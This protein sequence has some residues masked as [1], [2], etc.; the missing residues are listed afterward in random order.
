MDEDNKQPGPMTMQPWQKMR[1]QIKHLDSSLA[2]IRGYNPESEKV[3]QFIIG[4][5]EALE[6][7]ARLYDVG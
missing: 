7:A 6:W 1:E 3:R 5:I 2:A 4:Q